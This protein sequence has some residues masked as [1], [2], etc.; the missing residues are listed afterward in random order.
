[1]AKTAWLKNGK[2]I[3]RDGKVVM[4]GECPCDNCEHSC[5]NCKTGTAPASIRLKVNSFGSAPDSTADGCEITLYLRCLGDTN[6]SY[7]CYWVGYTIY[8]GMFVRSWATLGAISTP[9]GT[10]LLL[11]AS[12]TANGCKHSI[13]ASNH[14]TIDPEGFY[15]EGDVPYVDCASLLGLTLDEYTE[16][17]GATHSF[18]ILQIGSSPE[19]CDPYSPCPDHI[20]FNHPAAICTHAPIVT[21]M[22][23]PDGDPCTLIMDTTIGFCITDTRLVS[24]SGPPATSGTTYWT[25][26]PGDVPVYAVMFAYYHPLT[27]V[28]DC[29]LTLDRRGGKTVLEG[30]CAYDIYKA[31]LDCNNLADLAFSLVSHESCGDDGNMAACDGVTF[32]FVDSW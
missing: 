21:P 24:S 31:T 17:E 13:V 32:A 3:M 18:E 30:W 19:T 9:G 28:W 26:D 15:P 23:T 16:A 10:K 8:N 29:I 20:A 2:A 4:C 6:S 14:A 11:E 25:A 7:S 27:K 5:A 12:I 1:M 22:T